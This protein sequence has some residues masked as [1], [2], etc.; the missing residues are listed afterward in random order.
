MSPRYLERFLAFAFLNLSQTLLGQEKHFK[1]NLARL[2]DTRATT[3][4]SH[5]AI[6]LCPTWKNDFV[7]TSSCSRSIL[8][9]RR[10]CTTKVRAHRRSTK[11]RKDN[12][13]EHS[14]RAELCSKHREVSPCYTSELFFFLFFFF[15][16][17]V[18]Q[19]RCRWLYGA[20]LDLMFYYPSL[21]FSLLLFC[22]VDT[23]LVLQEDPCR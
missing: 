19:S 18:L 3:S 21:L 23:F 1:R 5:L 12:R 4:K 14:H 22:G 9:S 7:V 2:H 17:F 20:F 16:P 8:E 10:L 15:T 13:K 11:R 6:V